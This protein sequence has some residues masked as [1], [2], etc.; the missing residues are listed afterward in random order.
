MKS[1]QY[2]GNPA[3][4]NSCLKLKVFTNITV[5]IVTENSVYYYCAKIS[6]FRI[7]SS[8]PIGEIYG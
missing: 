8:P 7:Q 3:N 1:F 4:N 2:K 5:L 6:M